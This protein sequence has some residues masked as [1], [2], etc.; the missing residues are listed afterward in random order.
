VNLATNGETKRLLPWGGPRNSKDRASEHLTASQCQMLIDASM[1]A[2]TMGRPFNRFITGAWQVGGVEA[3]DSV[4]AT[5]AFISLAREW[6]RER[7]HP[8]PWVWVQEFGRIKGAHC[9]ILLHVP[10]DICPLFRGKPRQWARKV[11]G[12]H[13]VSGVIDS[14]RFQFSYST[15][16]FPDAYRA[17]LL[18]RLH[19]MLKCAPAALESDLGMIGASTA[20]WGQAGLVQGKRAAAWQGWRSF[21][22]QSNDKKG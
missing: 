22:G 10:P 7:G 16:L 17:E 13:Y 9:H 1:T 19:Y 5:G 20:P 15:Q 2:W 14:R 6:L 18:G 21:C 8:M 3:C 11:I 12:G 4:T